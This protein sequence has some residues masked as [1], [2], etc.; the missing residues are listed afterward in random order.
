[1]SDHVSV[2]KRGDVTH[3]VLAGCYHEQGL[4]VFQPLQ[5]C[6]NLLTGMHNTQHISSIAQYCQEQGQTQG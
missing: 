4:T 1:M 3:P 2:A 6:L 5:V